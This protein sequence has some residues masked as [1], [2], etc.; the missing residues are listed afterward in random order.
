MF[1]QTMGNA[2]LLHFTPTCLLF[3]DTSQA[4]SKIT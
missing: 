3:I 2:M 1:V 4:D